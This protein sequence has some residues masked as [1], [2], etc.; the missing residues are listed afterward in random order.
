MFVHIAAIQKFYFNQIYFNVISSTCVI[1]CDIDE[2]NKQGMSK[3]RPRQ[4]IFTPSLIKS[5]CIS[6]FLSTEGK[7]EG[8]E[9]RMEFLELAW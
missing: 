3:F 8:F 1:D 7:K 5:H 9:M 2:F 4:N 6:A